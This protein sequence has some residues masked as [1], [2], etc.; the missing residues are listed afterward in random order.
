MAL[1]LLLQLCLATSALGGVI[2]LSTE[3]RPPAGNDL[4][5]RDVLKRR[6]AELHA[7]DPLLESLYNNRQQGGYFINISIGTPPQPLS[8]LLDTGSSDLWVMSTETDICKSRTLQQ[9][10]GRACYGGLCE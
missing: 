8:V 3:K 4:V 6:A 7:R 9:E 2:K 10:V 1:S 5:H